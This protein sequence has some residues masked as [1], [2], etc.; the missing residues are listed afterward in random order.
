MSHSNLILGIKNFYETFDERLIDSLNEIYDEQIVFKD[1]FH[2]INGLNELIDYFKNMAENLHFCQF[3]F[4][5]EAENEENIFLEWEMIFAHK[6]INKSQ[7]VN[8]P[9]VSKLLINKDHKIT[10]QRD[11]FDSGDLLY[12]HLPFFKQAMRFIEKR[13]V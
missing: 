1:P 5:N 3:T 8:V 10:Y 6:H 2:T 13:M 11:Y 12:R 9:G 7:Q 4:I